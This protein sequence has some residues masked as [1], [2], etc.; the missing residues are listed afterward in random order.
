MF[1]KSFKND[2]RIS[3]NKMKVSMKKP[4]MLVICLIG[5]VA[6][7]VGAQL[8]RSAKGTAFSG[9][10][11]AVCLLII[12]AFIVFVLWTLIFKNKAIIKASVAEKDAALL[13]KPESEK[14]VIYL[15]RCQY[16]GMLAGM[17]VVLDDVLVGQTRGYCFYRFVVPPGSHVFSGAKKCQGP[18]TVDVAVGQIAYVE[19]SIVMGALKGGYQYQMADD[20]KKAQS[21]MRKCKLFLPEA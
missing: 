10:L 15:Y 7:L 20:V 21:S 11:W 9:L 3:I 8:A 14:G 12:A 13:F 4:N 2:L 19:Q 6:G 18:L 1:T 5:G 16:A 17:D